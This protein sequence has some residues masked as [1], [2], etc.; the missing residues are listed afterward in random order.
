MYAAYVPVI[1]SD[2]VLC[3]TRQCAHLLLAVVFYHFLLIFT[4]LETFLWS[5]DQYHQKF[6]EGKPITVLCGSVF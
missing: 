4:H 2:V 1:S 5:N 6:N 3:V